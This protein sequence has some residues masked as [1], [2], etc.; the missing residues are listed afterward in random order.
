MSVKS[1]G[2]FVAAKNEIV[3]KSYECANFQGHGNYWF[4]EINY[5]HYAHEYFFHY[6]H[7]LNPKTR[8][9]FKFKMAK[10]IKMY[11]FVMCKTKEQFDMSLVKDWQCWNE[12]FN[13]L[14]VISP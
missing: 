11:I 12:P 1:L 4:S 9:H 6:N 7:G 14:L 13:D 8:D 3:L 2:I 10:N 5:R